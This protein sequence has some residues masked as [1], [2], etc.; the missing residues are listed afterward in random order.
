MNKLALLALPFLFTS[1]GKDTDAST[2]H[3]LRFSAIPDQNT[4]ELMTKYEPVAD[5][6]SGKL[7]VK[8]EYVPVAQYAAS[9]Q[10]FKNGE[11]Q[12]AWFGGWTHIQAR[13][14]SPGAQALVMGAEDSKFHSYFLAHKDSGIQKSTGFPMEMKGKRFSFGSPSSTSGRLFPTKFIMDET[15]EKPDRFFKSIVYSGSHEQTLRYL[16]SKTVDCG[17]VNYEIY[18]RLTKAGKYDPDIIRVVWV[19]PNYPDYN[20][21][22]HGDLDKDFGEGFTEK[23]KK[24][25]LGMPSEMTQRF[26]RSRFIETKNSDFDVVEKIAREVGLLVR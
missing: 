8:V 15:G 17:V 2:V 21:T 13:V 12:L 19:T 18:D 14:G 16:A 1:C 23:L 10:Q 25:L 4:T 11:I 22:A 3:V 6:L 26:G 5:Y 20:F 9:V 7:N 24:V